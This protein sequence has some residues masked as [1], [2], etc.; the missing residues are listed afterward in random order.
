MP[1][2]TENLMQLF[3]VQNVETSA[4][5]HLVLQKVC[6]MDKKNKKQKQPLHNC[7]KGGTCCSIRTGMGIS[8]LPT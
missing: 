1:T 3:G 7:L 2:E 8:S 4:V 5:H 6:V